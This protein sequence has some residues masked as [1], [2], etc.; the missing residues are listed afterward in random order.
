MASTSR[1]NSGSGLDVLAATASN[2]RRL[3]S[4]W[5]AGLQLQQHQQRTKI[6]D[7]AE[8][9][10]DDYDSPSQACETKTAGGLRRKGKWTVR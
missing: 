9:N 2:E 4:M 8:A 6:R 3:S 7:V 10:D 1:V 5:A